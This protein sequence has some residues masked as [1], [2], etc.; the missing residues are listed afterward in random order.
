MIKFFT[1]KILKVKNRAHSLF[2]GPEYVILE[3]NQV[4]PNSIV[5]KK[6]TPDY[7]YLEKP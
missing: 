1:C 3:K 4:T 5:K 7:R 2:Q 6:L